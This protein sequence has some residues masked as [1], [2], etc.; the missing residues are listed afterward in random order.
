[1]AWGVF[2]VFNKDSKT[3]ELH[4][5]PLGKDK[6]I[7]PNHSL[8]KWCSCSPQL[9]PSDQFPRIYVHSLEQ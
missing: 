1:M 4:I 9:I 8:S 5:V 7:L 3:E 2:T 6:R